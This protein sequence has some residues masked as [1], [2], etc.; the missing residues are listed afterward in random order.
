MKTKRLIILI[1]SLMAYINCNALINCNS[2]CV[3]NI[4]MDTSTTHT[5]DVTIFMAGTSNDFIDYPYIS[6]ITDS[7]GDTIATGMMNFFGQFGNTSQTYQV[8]TS[9]DSIP[10]NFHCTLYFKYD[11][12]TCTL[13]YPC[14]LSGIEEEYSF[15]KVLI[16]PNPSAGNFILSYHLSTSVSNNNGCELR[17]IDYTG[18]SVYNAPITG[19]VGKQ[20]ITLSDLCNGVYYWQLISNNGIEGNGKIALIKN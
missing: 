13:L 7:I 9:W 1:V 8:N 14:T 11:S 3:T 20:N 16:Y 6:V 10:A 12:V 15:N 4:Q 2:F 18:R 17:I 5:M 19:A